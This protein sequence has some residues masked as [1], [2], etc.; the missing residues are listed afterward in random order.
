MDTSTLR[1]QLHTY[2]ERY[3]SVYKSLSPEKVL[4][5][6]ILSALSLGAL[7]FA[8]V[9]IN[10]RYVIT[11]PAL[12]GSVTEGVVGT[13]RFINPVLATSNQD[14]DI[15]SLVFSG[16]TSLDAQGTVQLNLASSITP[17]EDGLTYTV[18]LRDD[19]T[20]HDGTPLTSDDVLYTVNLIQ[21][22]L[23]KSPHRIELE[24]VSVEKTSATSLVFTLKQPYPL[25]TR[26]LTIGILPKHIW[27]NLTE[28]QFSLS[29]YNIHAIGSGPYKIESI[30]SKSGIP[31]DIIL[32]SNED[33]TLGRPYI[34]QITISTYQNEKY[35]I[36]AFNSGDIDRIHGI[37]PDTLPSLTRSSSRIETTLLPRTFSVFFNPNKKELLSDKN[38]RKALML[39]IDKDAIVRDVFKGYAQTINIPFAFDVSDA[40]TATSTYNPDLARSILAKNAAFKKASSTLSITL[41]TANTDDMKKVA[42]MLKTY[43]E[44]IGVSTTVTVYEV[45]DL[46]QVIIKERDFEALLYGS[47]AETPSDLYAF[48]HSS[49]R[50]SPGLNISNYVSKSLDT[51]LATLRNSNNEL[52]RVSAYEALRQEFEDEVPG[53]ALFAPRLLYIINDKVTTTLPH[54]SSDRSSRFA[55]V[56]QWYRYTEHVWNMSYYKKGI[57]LLQNIIH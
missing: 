2:R 21:N 53:I 50:T 55:L 57:G 18:T 34:E 26:V 42:D 1:Q 33:Y 52:E 43:W 38:I 39:A 51:N 45:S 47:I 25:F 31:E 40:D 35:L 13:P 41:T 4:A 32:E 56:E 29:D 14:K 22:P 49:Q 9:A 23:I 7:F 54:F 46:T 36:E 6:W 11:I 5:L 12:G 19:I 20:F 44:A 28:E 48:W 30:V 10:T 3:R 27:K 15:T 37:S 8:L 24:G 16:L 17:S